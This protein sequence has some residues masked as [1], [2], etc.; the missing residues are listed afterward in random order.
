[1][2]LV[3]EAEAPDVLLLFFEELPPAAM[4]AASELAAAAEPTPLPA[5]FRNR[6]RATSS[7]A[8]SCTAPSVVGVGSVISPA[9]L[10]ND[11]GLVPRLPH[12]RQGGHCGSPGNANGRPPEGA[13]AWK[14]MP[15][16]RL[17]AAR[18]SESS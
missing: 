18:R 14:V 1:M 12:L 6:L 15:W 16:W 10:E 2:E 4:K 13:P 9:F 11:R 8:S 3:L 7:R 5:I 17:Y